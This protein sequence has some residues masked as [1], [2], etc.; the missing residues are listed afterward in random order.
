MPVS[1]SKL[2]Y[3]G[4][5][6]DGFLLLR[7]DTALFETGRG[8]PSFVHGGNSPQE[9]VVPVLTVVRAR[10]AAPATTTYRVEAEPLPDEQGFRAVQVRIRPE[11][12]PQGTLGY[13]TPATI[14]LG[15]RAFGQP[16]VR[17]V[18]VQSE[19]PGVTVIL[20]RKSYHGHYAYGHAAGPDFNAACERAAMELERHDFVVRQYLLVHTGGIDDFMPA[21]THAIERRSVYFAQTE[22]HE[23]FQERLRAPCSASPLAPRL[24]YDGPVPGAWSA[25]AD[26]W[27][28][29][30]APPS[31]R[32]L[33]NDAH[34]F[35]W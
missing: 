28:V 14:D 34:Y 3:E 9:R 20:Y 7:E 35:F 33:S 6:S 13:V 10:K 29:V 12:Q 25:Y 24:V 2:E 22:G 1:L 5:G 19:L 32:F 8:L 15:L 27:R 30:Y 16:D 18:V 21:S 26:V 4:A 11:R 17:A 31:E 23:K